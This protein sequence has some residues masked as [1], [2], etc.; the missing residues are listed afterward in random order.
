MRRVGAW[1]V[2]LFGAVPPE[3][4]AGAGLEGE[5]LEL[6]RRRIWAATA[7]LASLP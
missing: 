2:R 7:W 6:G 4:M 3:E 1:Q 5:H